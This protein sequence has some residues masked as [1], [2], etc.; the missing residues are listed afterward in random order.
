LAARVPKSKEEGEFRL[1]ELAL[2]TV[3]EKFLLLFNWF[4]VELPFNPFA[5]AVIMYIL[6]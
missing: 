5:I 6:D 1:A 2:Y 3:S 4:L